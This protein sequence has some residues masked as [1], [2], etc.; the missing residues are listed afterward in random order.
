MWMQVS[1]GAIEKPKQVET[2]AGLALVPIDSIEELDRSQQLLSTMIKLTVTVSNERLKA[3]RAW[4]S[5]RHLTRVAPGH[6]D[7]AEWHDLTEQVEEI[8]KLSA[9]AGQPSSFSEQVRESIDL[10]HAA[11]KGA[12]D[13]AQEIVAHLVGSGAGL[14]EAARKYEMSRAIAEIR[15]TLGQC[16]ATCDGECQDGLRRIEHRVKSLLEK[17]A[18]PQESSARPTADKQPRTSQEK[19]PSSSAEMDDRKATEPGG[20][21]HLKQPKE[22]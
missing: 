5:A 16:A 2:P 1:P 15:R 20:E 7:V 4:V 8:A 6:G 12:T 10:F 11:R 3:E 17:V 21:G 18:R 14:P 22:R 9:T 19:Q 13:T